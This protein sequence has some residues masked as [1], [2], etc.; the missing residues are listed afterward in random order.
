MIGGQRPLR[1][2]RRIREFGWEPHVLTVPER[3]CEPADP[4]LGRDVRATTHIERVACWNLYHHSIAWY[5]AKS[6]VRRAVLKAGRGVGY[7]LSKFMPLDL[8]YLWALAA[9]RAGISMVRRLGVDLIWATSPVNSTILLAHRVSRA[10]GVPFVADFRDVR[11]KLKAS[12]MTGWNRRNVQIE[13]AALRGAAGISVSAPVQR[14]T[15]LAKHGAVVE[16]PFLLVHNWFEAEEAQGCTAKVFDRPTI[17]HG[18]VLYGGTRRLDG[19]LEALALLRGNGASQEARRLQFCQHGIERTDKLLSAMSAKLGLSGTVVIGAYLDRQG[20][21]SHCR[22]ARILLLAVGRNERGREHAQA[23]PGKLYDYFAT[24]RP[25]LV[26]G[27]PDCEAGRMVERVHRGMAVADDSPGEIAEAIE[28]LL[29]GKGRNGPLD[30]SAEA[31]SEFESHSAIRRIASFFDGVAGRGFGGVAAGSACGRAVDGD[32][33]AGL[34]S[35][36]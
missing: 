4:D 17:I 13:R 32:P 15:L 16:K 11:P 29:D 35:R 18:G 34:M 12:R 19:F 33:E 1:V 9:T 20:F 21:L 27:P 23:I 8:D 22:G 24:Q 3:C 31:V 10:T 2:V 6:I 26:V 25:V 5:P 14:E 36:G 28:R 7:A 30:L